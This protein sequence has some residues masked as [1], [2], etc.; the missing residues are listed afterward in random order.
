M[1]KLLFLWVILL[2]SLSITAQNELKFGLQTGATASTFTTKVSIGNNFA[3]AIPPINDL[4]HITSFHAGFWFE[5]RF[6]RAL[7]LRWEVQRTPGG[8]TAIDPATD[9]TRR[10]KFFSIGSPLILKLT[11]FQSQARYPIQ[12]EAGIKANY[13]LFDYGEEVTFGNVEKLEYSTILGLSKNIDD[14]WSVSVRYIQGLTPFSRYDAGGLTVEWSNQLYVLSF[15]RSLFT[16]QK[17]G[18]KEG[19]KEEVEPTAKQ[20]MIAKNRAAAKKKRKKAAK[21]RKKQRKKK[22]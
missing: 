3:A 7:A 11:T 10:Y 15:S 8:A 20:K 22:K 13:F 17:K 2:S 14:N 12:L 6:N 1:R 4:G 18:V 5:K 9:R 16:I 21:K 19:A